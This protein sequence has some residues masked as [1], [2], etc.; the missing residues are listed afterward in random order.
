MSKLYDDRELRSIQVDI[1]KRKRKDGGYSHWKPAEAEAKEIIR[2]ARLGL[3]FEKHA[4]PALHH[5]NELL[6]LHELPDATVKIALA[7]IRKG[8]LE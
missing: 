2:L 7:T 3:Q 5:A 4:L 1:L 6:D 8:L